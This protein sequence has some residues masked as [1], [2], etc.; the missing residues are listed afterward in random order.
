MRLTEPDERDER[1]GNNELVCERIQEY[2]ERGDGLVSARDDAVERVGD[3]CRD[4]DNEGADTRPEI[5][6]IHEKNEKR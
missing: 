3:R 1:S 2:T 4:E 5:I 6:D